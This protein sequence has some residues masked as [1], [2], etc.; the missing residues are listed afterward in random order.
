MVF[1]KRLELQGFKSFASKTTLEFPSRVTAIVGPNGSGK[2]N[3]I[4]AFRWVLGER[5]AK[6]LRGGTLENL[7]FSGTP[8]R[9]AVGF[10]R[11][12]LCFDN[13]N[14]MFEFGEREVAV[15]RKIDRSGASQ[16]FINDEEI[17][18]K[19]L[20][21][22]LA[23]AKLGSRGLTMIGQGQGDLFVRSTPQER[24]SMIEEVLGLKEFRLKKTQAEKRL[25]SSGINMEKV[26]AMIDE[27]LPHLRFLRKQK[28]RWDKRGEIENELR[29]IENTYYASQYNSLLDKLNAISSPKN[30]FLKEKREKESEINLLEEKL[31]V[32]D[33][34]AD[35]A[36]RLKELRKEIENVFNE[37]SQI[38]KELAKLE[39]RIEFQLN[40]KNETKYTTQELIGVVNDAKQ[41]IEK[42]VDFD[43]VSKM[44]ELLDSLLKK[45]KI[46]LGDRKEAADRNFVSEQEEFK[47][48]LSLCDEKINKLRDEEESVARDQQ[49]KNEAFRNLFENIEK[50]KNELRR[51]EQEMQSHVFENEKLQLRMEELEREWLSIGRNISELK[52][53]EKRNIDLDLVEMNKRMLKLRGE[54]AAIGEID[55]SLVKEADE[56][57]SR[58][59]FLTKELDDLEKAS[60]DLKK[61]IKDLD[62][63][64]NEDFENAFKSINEEFNKYFRLMFVGGKAK[65]KM[66]KVHVPDENIS[67]TSD[68][69][70]SNIK[71]DVGNGDLAEKETVT[72]GI[73]IELVLPKKK[74]TSLDMLSGGEKSLVSIAALFA[75]ISVSPPPFLVL[76]EIDA[77]LDDN[78]ARRFAELVKEF[79][80][81]SQFIIVTHNRATMEAADILY[82]VTMADDGVSKILSLKLETAS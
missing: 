32:A 71:S 31:K 18:L 49:K 4:D 6:Q 25:E 1:L 34:T 19:D 67:T 63:K 37:R 66:Q 24:R 14:E 36:L 39:V 50:L 8:K 17:R 44:K 47:K 76:D 5:E 43:D 62:I 27:L 79:S 9:A 52:N 28:H 23:R 10:A 75:L 16:F 59:L 41:T 40:E 13:S 72:A 68:T 61:L 29:E 33:T 73:D 57:E 46:F 54:L 7:I 80:S 22:M 82:G 74:I 38:E 77:P 81:H 56:S 3:I 78:N 35:D 58:Y 70:D 60:A 69:A 12:S 21:P 26:K 53:I 20:S 11:V 51:I 64:I 45:L 2:S 30:S 65:M 48:K 42:V 55:E 15:E